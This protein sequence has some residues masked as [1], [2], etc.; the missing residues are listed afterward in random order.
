MFKQGICLPTGPCVS[1]K[2]VK[3]IVE[4]IKNAIIA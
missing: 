3:Y 2:D 4:T 1:D